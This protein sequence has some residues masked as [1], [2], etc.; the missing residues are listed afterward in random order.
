MACSRILLLL[1]V[2]SLVAFAAPSAS[3]QEHLTTVS[4]VYAVNFNVRIASTLPAGT[5]I[6]CRAQ[7]VPGQGAPGFL[8][9]QWNA[10]PVGTAAGL[11]AVTGSTATCAAE[12]PFSWTVTSG[13]NGVMLS[14]E[15]DAVTSSGSATMLVR[16]SALQGISAAFPVSGGSAS[17]SF[18]VAL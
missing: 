12:I 13:Q 3:C 15:I 8:N 18:N 16:R 7:I 2:A 4:G 5:T 9:Q 11:A 17:L 6:T 1:S 10:Y 14:Y